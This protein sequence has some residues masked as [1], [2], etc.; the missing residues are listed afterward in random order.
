ME[1][2]ANADTNLEDSIDVDL[3]RVWKTDEGGIG[4]TFL[5]FGDGAFHG[6][7]LQVNAEVQDDS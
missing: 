4:R 6:R 3:V 1:L 2:I 7:V 5:E